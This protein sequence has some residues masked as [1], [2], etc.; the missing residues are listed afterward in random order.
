M[1][2]NTNNTEA[3]KKPIYRKQ[4]PGNIS[5]A[6]FANTNDGRTF[7][8]INLQRSYRTRSGEWQ[9]QSI[10]LEYGDILYAIEAL[11][12]TFKF[13]SEGAAAYVNSDA[14]DEPATDAIEAPAEA[15]A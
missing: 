4:M 8:S 15:Q 12:G 13:L 7:Y 2:T 1:T 3:K 6:I 14:D 11:R 10:F 5:T 9:R